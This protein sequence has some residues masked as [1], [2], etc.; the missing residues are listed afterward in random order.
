LPRSSRDLRTQLRSLQSRYTNAHPEVVDTAARL[1]RV[2][3][4]LKAL[5]PDPPVT[6]DS[7]D[8][9]AVTVR[10]Q[11][12]DREAKRLGEEQKRIEIVRREIADRERQGSAA[13]RVAG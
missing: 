6:A 7:K 10:L 8:N 4:Q 1:K 2:D 12:S 5:P 3:D 11:L 13:G 9:N